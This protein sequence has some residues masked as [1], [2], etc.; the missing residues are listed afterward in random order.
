MGKSMLWVCEMCFKYMT[1]GPSWELH[2]VRC[3]PSAI[4]LSP[5]LK[6]QKNC[7]VLHPPGLKVYQRGA[8]TIW[9][10][11]GAKAKVR[12]PPLPV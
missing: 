8:H 10:V 12:A 6:L 7:D 11:D 3:L 1:D 4:E 9:E 2:Q 5:D